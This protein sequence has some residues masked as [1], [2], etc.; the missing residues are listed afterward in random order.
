[1]SDQHETKEDEKD[2]EFGN[3]PTFSNVSV[4]TCDDVATQQMIF[5][6]LP[7]SKINKQLF[8][9]WLLEEHDKH[10]TVSDDGADQGDDEGK[11]G[12]VQQPEV[13]GQRAQGSGGDVA[14]Q[15]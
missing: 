1:M 2:G 15:L 11:Q 9:K 7:L 3:K 10:G 8:Y 4:L 5:D 6:R 13:D 14:I 12:E